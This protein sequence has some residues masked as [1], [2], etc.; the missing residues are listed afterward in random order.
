MAKVQLT[1]EVEP[2][3]LRQIERAAE[4]DDTTVDRWVQKAIRDRLHHPAT[5]SDIQRHA[6]ETTP[7]ES[8]PSIVTIRDK[9][10]DSVL[11]D[12]A[13]Q[14]ED[15]CPSDYHSGQR[16]GNPVGIENPP[17]LNDGSSIFDIVIED[18]R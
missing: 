10:V 5:A 16:G 6:R 11:Q 1:A 3:L 7:E 17:R 2:E 4:S 14:R 9:T 13:Q 18:R 15:S 8:S 12:E